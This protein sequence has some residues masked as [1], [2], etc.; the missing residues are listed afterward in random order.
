M[1]GLGGRVFAFFMLGGMGVTF[2]MLANVV[3][4]VLGGFG[5]VFGALLSVLAVMALFGRVARRKAGD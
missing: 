3:G 4:G 2:F 1:S 5:Y